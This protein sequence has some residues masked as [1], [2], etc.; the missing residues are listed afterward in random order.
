MW[1]RRPRARIPCG[2]GAASRSGGASN[3]FRSPRG[4][5]GCPRADTPLPAQAAADPEAPQGAYAAPAAPA[6]KAQTRSG[7][8]AAP[9]S[10]PQAYSAPTPAPAATPQ[11]SIPGGY[12]GP[13][14]QAGA[15]AGG[16]KSSRSAAPG[17]T[18]F[19]DY[20]RQ[21]AVATSE[22]AVSTFSLD[23]DRTSYHLA[24]NWAREGYEV[25]PDSV[26]AEEW[27]NAFDYRYDPPADG[28]GFAISSEVSDASVGRRKAPRAH[29]VPGGS[30]PGRPTAQRDSGPRRVGVDGRGQPCRY[31]SRRGG[32]HQAE[33][34]LS[35]P[36]SRRPLHRRRDQG[37]TRSSTAPAGR[38][39][40]PELDRPSRPAR[41]HQRASRIE[42]GGQACGPGPQVGVRTPTITSS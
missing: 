32:G 19:Q 34:R 41:Q 26:R 5:Q 30:R 7:P 14:P 10:A 33:P 2:R 25:E 24:L 38:L 39:C 23:T 35:G 29:L 37:N 20:R 13:T 40:G 21:P 3:G 36:H 12:P 27:I 31:R 8:A 1:G 4:A 42:L 16:P 22:D 18:T 6:S 15:G 11:S 28:W 9:T 17:A